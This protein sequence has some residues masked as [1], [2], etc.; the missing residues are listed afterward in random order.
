MG[1]LANFTWCKSTRAIHTNQQIMRIQ[2]NEPRITFLHLFMI[3]SFI[4]LRFAKRQTRFSVKSTIHRRNTVQQTNDTDKNEISVEHKYSP[5]NTFTPELLGLFN[6]FHHQFHNLLSCNSVRENAQL[7]KQSIWITVLHR[8][9]VES[10]NHTSNRGTKQ[11][12]YNKSIKPDHTHIDGS[13]ATSA[14]LLFLFIRRRFNKL[15]TNTRF[16]HQKM[17]NA[18]NNCCH[19]YGS[20]YDPQLRF[21]RD[22]HFCG[23]FF[24]LSF[25]S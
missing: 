11:K 14:S 2:R 17:F 10:N 1:N 20:S 12:G 4:S 15:L 19:Q 13:T 18:K 8:I 22:T 9:L 6:R 16:T 25:P 23:V 7:L 21:I 3:S 5:E 24:H